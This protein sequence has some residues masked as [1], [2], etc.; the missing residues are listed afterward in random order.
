MSDQKG[1]GAAG[2]RPGRP[3]VKAVCRSFRFT[4][5]DML[6]VNT[7]EIT[8][9][10]L[11]AYLVEKLRDAIISRKLGAGDRLNETTL[12]SRYNVSRVAMREAL[13]KLKMQG[14]VMNHPRRGMFVNSLT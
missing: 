7:S 13:M 1:I 10:V 12:A 8:S 9:S 14:L 6:D 5:C 4:I 2:R 11:K 3:S